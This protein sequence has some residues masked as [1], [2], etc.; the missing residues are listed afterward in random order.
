[1]G[2]FE[3]IGL[4]VCLYYLFNIICWCLLDSDIELFI[5][6]KFGEPIA[7]L[8]GKVVWVTGA[9][10]GIGRA[11][12][13]KLA[14]HNVRL[15][16]SARRIVNLQHV[17]AECLQAST[18]LQSDDILILPMDI[19]EIDRHT[20]YFE[21]VSNHFDGQLDVLVNN[22]GRSQRALFKD[23]D[24][25]VDRD[26]FELDVF[27]IINLTRIYVNYAIRNLNGYGHV[28]VTSSAVGLISVPN[29]ASYNGAKHAIHGYLNTLQLE[30]PDISVSLFC[31]GPT[32][33]EFLE[34]CFTDKS[35]KI[36]GET[37]KP[38]DKRMT[39]E[40]CAHLMATAIANKCNVNFVGTF[41]VTLLLYISC[42]YPN[43]KKLAMTLLGREGLNK[44]R[45]SNKKSS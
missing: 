14:K 8:Q 22:A 39:A 17:K 33:T 4:F 18:S 40:R 11:L 38:T 37:V 32:Y 5:K 23:I 34:N 41:P 15:C 12:A 1:M 21:R 45:D 13:L 19:L 29:S 30:Q 2:F 26:M 24:L 27:S 42:Y 9:S 28:A 6:E 10:S 16:L 7:S 43:L 3:I 36:Y 20:E 25:K 31:P 44:I 35:G